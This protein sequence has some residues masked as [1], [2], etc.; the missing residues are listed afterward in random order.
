MDTKSEGVVV[1]ERPHLKP[2]FVEI[3]NPS[4]RWAIGATSWSSAILG[5]R[6]EKGI[7]ARTVAALCSEG[8]QPLI[9]P[10]LTDDDVPRRQSGQSIASPDEEA[11]R[12]L[13]DLLNSN[14]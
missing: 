5:A 12:T 14:R 11:V 1:I 9:P 7:Y 6:N 8:S 13:R 2:N 3:N 4:L 10:I